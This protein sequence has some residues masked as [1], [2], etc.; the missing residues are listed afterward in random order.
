MLLL[1]A[2]ADH[3]FPEDFPAEVRDAA[4]LRAA[5][6]GFPANW[7]LTGTLV[8]GR[9][10]PVPRGRLVGGS[11]ALNGGS[12]IRGT[13]ADFD[14]WAAAGN[15]RW[16]YDAVLPAFRRL[17]TDADFGAEPGAR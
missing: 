9:T 2:G 1:E 12:F 17:E 4:T 8:E 5:E 16:S 3:A 10:V 13:R 14:G 15:D 6:P 11:S 7:D